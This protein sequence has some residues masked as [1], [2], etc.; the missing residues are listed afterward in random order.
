MVKRL[1]FVAL[2]LVI[3]FGGVFSFDAWRS[4][5]AQRFAQ[6]FKLP[7]V[8]VGTI[9][10]Q[11]VKWSSKISAIGSLVAMN[12][13][14]ITS[15]INGKVSKI[16]FQSGQAVT[17]DQPIV[18][19]DDKILQQQLRENIAQ[20]ELSRLNFDRSKKLYQKNT[21]S[22]QQLDVDRAAFVKYQA[23]V[24]ADKINIDYKV[25]K[26]PF[27]GRLGIRE[28][29]I[30]Q[31]LDPG[32]PIVR[33][34]TLDPILID[35]TIPERYLSQIKEEQVFSVIVDAYPEEKFEGKVIAINS[36]V[37]TQTRNIT[38]RGK[39]SNSKLK[40]YPGQ[41]AKVSLNSGQEQSVIIVPRNAITYNTYGNILYVV[42]TKD[43]KK[44]AKQINV[45]TGRQRGDWVEI[46]A[47]VNVGDEVIVSGQIKVRPNSPVV[48]NNTN[49]LR[50][51]SW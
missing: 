37:N 26:A 15:D 1:I 38:L 3:V 4:Y 22:K 27:D 23:A 21:I 12:S 47:G 13:V 16:L 29:N 35:F 2:F 14:K 24:N 45:K 39:L 17:K 19:L 41:F 30:G 6:Q 31:F 5:Q 40:L 20:L 9:K 28:V 18:Q 25:V 36:T 43:Q 44:I 42:E 49:P 34:E 10:A 50:Y 8:T 11:K 48:I 32:D 7:P 46:T 33:V 51:Q